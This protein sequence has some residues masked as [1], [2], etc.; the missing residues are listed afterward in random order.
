MITGVQYKLYGVEAL[1]DRIIF[2][3]I[4]TFLPI[5][6]L[7]IGS[8]WL[9]VKKKISKKNKRMGFEP[10]LCAHVLLLLPAE[11]WWLYE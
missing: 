5:S 6:I 10:G 8:I 11:P 3:Y 9:A 2:A 7:V 1:Y 4:G